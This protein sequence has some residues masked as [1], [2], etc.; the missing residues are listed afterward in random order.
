LEP[1]QDPCD[2]C[3]ATFF[4]STVKIFPGIRNGYRAEGAARRESRGTPKPI[5]RTKVSRNEQIQKDIMERRQI[6]MF[7]WYILTFSRFTTL[8]IGIRR[9][10]GVLGIGPAQ[11]EYIAHHIEA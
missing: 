7:S 4:H 6:P 1:R 8:E 2:S 3:S 9:E 11:R 10:V 5:F